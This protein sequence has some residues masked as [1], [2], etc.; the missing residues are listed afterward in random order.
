VRQADPLR[1]A[2]RLIAEACGL[3]EAAATQLDD[4]R[5][6]LRINAVL[7]DVRN[8]LAAAERRRHDP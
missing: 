1:K 7:L 6:T 4:P 3:L 2:A 8:A 5:L